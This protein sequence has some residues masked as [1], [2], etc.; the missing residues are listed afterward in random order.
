MQAKRRNYHHSS[1]G[2]SQTSCD[3]KKVIKSKLFRRRILDIGKN[4][5]KMEA[6]KTIKSRNDEFL[7]VT[8]S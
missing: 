2:I 4:E 5:K 7:H 8:I 1:F 6:A 3:N